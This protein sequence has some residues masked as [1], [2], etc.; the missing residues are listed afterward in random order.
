[1]NAVQPGLFR[2]P[3]AEIMSRETWES[4]VADTPLGRAGEPRE[5]A[6]AVLFLACD[7]AS[8]VTGAVLEVTG[9]RDM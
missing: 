6:T 3:G 7:L 5:L 2:T 8:F 1:V 9:G 4:R